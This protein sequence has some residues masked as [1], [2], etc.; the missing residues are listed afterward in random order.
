M[1]AIIITV[2]D[3]ILIGQIVN[4]NA[5]W[6]G[7][8][9]FSLGIHV[10]KHLSV[11]DSEKEIISSFRDSWRKFDIV[12]VTG[13]LGPTPDDITKT[14][15]SKF[16]KSPLVI[17]EK[18]LK[19]VKSIFRRRK[20]P[21]AES[22]IGQAMIPRTAKALTNKAGTAPGI[23]IDK[24]GKIFCSLPGVPHEMKY[25]CETGLFP[26]VK[27][28]YKNAKNKKVLLQKTIHTIG[29]SESLLAN[30]IGVNSILKK[31][32]NS[33]V[34]LAFLPNNFEVRLRVTVEAPDINTARALIT[35]SVKKIKQKAGKYIYSFNESSIEKAVGDSLKKKGLK[36]AIAESCTG[37]L[38]AS[39]ITDVNGSANYF[40]EGLVCYSNEAKMR[41]LGVKKNTLKANG[42]VSEK[43][44]VEMADGARKKAKADIAISTTGIA[45]PTGATREKPVG[46]VWIGYSDKNKSFAKKFVFVKNNKIK[47]KLKRNKIAK[48][49]L[50]SLIDN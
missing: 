19:D 8:K 38:I 5:S 2:G 1:K 17:N 30:I 24:K 49:I 13:G 25:I 46:L 21:M 7:S 29:I 36:L 28:K 34:K 11:S 6:L 48:F 18:I 32:K 40:L 3:E 15:I 10:D 14:C 27:E 44:A 43:V 47:V 35:A 50:C 31:D 23:L 26:Y 4:T 42:A 12:I 33:E 22:N 9:L 45:G 20:I 16:F 41:L 37:G 39:K